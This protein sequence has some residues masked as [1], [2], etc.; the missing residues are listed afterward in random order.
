MT[1]LAKVSQKMTNNLSQ[2]V[3]GKEKPPN[4]L[5]RRGVFGGANEDR[6]HDLYN[7]IVRNAQ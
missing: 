7:A 1:T 4:A 3:G 5:K 6:T 2:I